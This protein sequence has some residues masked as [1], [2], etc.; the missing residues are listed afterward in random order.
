[1]ADDVQKVEGDDGGL[2]VDGCCM[3]A[4]AYEGSVLKNRPETAWLGALSVG[5]INGGRR[6]ERC[7]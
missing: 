3:G 6:L 7:C 5:A 4:G 2:M 1:M